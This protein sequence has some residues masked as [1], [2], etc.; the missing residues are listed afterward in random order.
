MK[1]LDSIAE[2]LNPGYI[3]HRWE[4]AEKEAK[5]LLM[6]VECYRMQMHLAGSF[7]TWNGC[8][9]RFLY[10]SDR[11]SNFL[12]KDVAIDAVASDLLAGNEP[13]MI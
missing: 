4:W 9:Q 2:N 12:P 10:Q 11:F 6:Q 13:R 5:R 3:K 8:N 1:R 7:W